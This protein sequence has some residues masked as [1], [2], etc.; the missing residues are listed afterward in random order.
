MLWSASPSRLALI[1]AGSSKL[2]PLSEAPSALVQSI[3]TPCRL[4]A[5][6]GWTTSYMF[7]AVHVCVCSEKVVIIENSAH[8]EAR[9]GQ[10]CS[11]QVCPAQVGMSQVGSSQVGHLKVDV[12]QIQTR[13][14]CT[15]KVETLTDHKYRKYMCI[16]FHPPRYTIL[17][18][19]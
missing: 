18:F 11:L 5:W 10:V 14:I 1:P 6:E 15:I 19:L 12:A 7:H 4:A 9:H 3:F 17:C 16:C 13:Q 2:Q 8:V